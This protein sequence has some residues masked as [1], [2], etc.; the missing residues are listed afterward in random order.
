MCHRLL[1]GISRANPAEPVN[2]SGPQS[3]PQEQPA[4]AQFN[5]REWV[6]V[7][8]WRIQSVLDKPC[9]VWIYILQELPRTRFGFLISYMYLGPAAYLL[10][11]G[12]ASMA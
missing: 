9:L 1:K 5:L 3:M 12:R 2:L 4:V 7:E 8:R 6:A 11:C 10:H